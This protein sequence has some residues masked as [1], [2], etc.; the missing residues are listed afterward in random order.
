MKKRMLAVVIII[1]AVVALIL[2]VWYVLF[3]CFGIGPAFPFMNVTV[4]ELEQSSG[5]MSETEPLMA[6]A[7][8]EEEAKN[9]A[10]Q[11]GIFFVS[12]QNGVA[13]YY[14]DEDPYQ[15]I[16]RGEENGYPVV[17]INY[18]RELFD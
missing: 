9:I 18:K 8:T 13:T 11:Y 5:E 16:A 1:V 17:Y 10:Q 2:A 12:F 14:T 3:C 15:V 4:I 7:E 6:L